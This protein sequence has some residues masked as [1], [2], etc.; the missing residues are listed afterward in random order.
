MS[1]GGHSFWDRAVVAVI[2]FV[3]ENEEERDGK[4]EEMDRIK[5]DFWEGIILEIQTCSKP[6]K[7]SSN[8][9]VKWKTSVFRLPSFHDTKKFL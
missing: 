6:K 8:Q 4:R 7:A 5:Q 9:K 3:Q 1:V 2:T